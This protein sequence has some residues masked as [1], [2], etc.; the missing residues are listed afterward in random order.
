MNSL[1]VFNG[2]RGVNGMNNMGIMGFNFFEEMGIMEGL[3]VGFN[4]GMGGNGNIGEIFGIVRVFGMRN[5]N[6]L[7]EFL[8]MVF[9]KIV[10]FLNK[11]SKSVIKE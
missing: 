10:I 7:F 5:V 9:K 4:S 3:F 11:K 8:W 2:I 1:N 6:I